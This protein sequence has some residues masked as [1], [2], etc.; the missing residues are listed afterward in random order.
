M[1]INE[2]LLESTSTSNNTGHGV[3][4][5][6]VESELPPLDKEKVQIPM[7]LSNPPSTRRQLN[8]Y[9]SPSKSILASTNSDSHGVIILNVERELPHLGKEKGQRK[10]PNTC[11]A[12]QSSKHKKAVEH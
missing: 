9:E 5:L 3:I 2:P 6:N 11:G 4:V 8:I 1:N 10:S 7:V 12:E